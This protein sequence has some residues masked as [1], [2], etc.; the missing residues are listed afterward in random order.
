MVATSIQRACFATLITA[1]SLLPGL[2]VFS[3]SLLRSDYASAYPLVV[4][5]TPKLSQRG[6]TAIEQMGCIIRDV[7]PI[8]A[9]PT[10]NGESVLAYAHFSEVW[11]KLRAFDLTEYDKVVLVDSDMLVRRNMDE[12]FDLPETFW[13][14]KKIAA[15]F[16]CTCNPRKMGTYPANWIPENCGFRLQTRN[17]LNVTN[18][19]TR[20]GTSAPETHNLLNSGLVVL[21]P[22]AQVMEM[23]VHKIST[24]AGVNDYRFPDQDFLAD[25]HK[26]RWH[27]LP[28]TYNALKP[29]RYCQSE[30]WVDEEVKNVHYIIDKPWLSGPPPPS[31]ADF[32]THSWWWE[33]YRSLQASTRSNLLMELWTE[34]IEKN[35]SE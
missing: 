1:E 22:D 28:W 13:E 5:V 23:I 26:G 32:V 17:T 21:T 11:T 31:S 35:V 34:L 20:L 27:I 33:A 10:H 7:S 3:H 18:N 29:L 19:T 16:A 24:D 25:L 9:P 2:A 15:T 14:A 6:R 8:Y 4:M 30:M 12:L